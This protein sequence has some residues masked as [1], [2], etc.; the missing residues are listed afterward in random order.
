[1]RIATLVISLCLLG[2]GNINAQT[3]E[4]KNPSPG[5]IVMSDDA[6]PK[7]TFRAGASTIDV[8]AERGVSVQDLMVAAKIRPT[9]DPQTIVDKVSTVR[10]RLYPDRE[11]SLMVSVPRNS[12][13]VTS[14]VGL[15]RY[16][17]LWNRTSR[18]NAYWYPMLAAATFISDV[19][20]TW[21]YYECN[22][23]SKYRY[24]AQI[25]NG[26]SYTRALAGGYVYRGFDYQPATYG[27]R[28]DIVMYFF[29]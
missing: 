25:G 24:A 10:A 1:V 12:E 11:I 9:D 18:A 29:N 19:R 16:Y 3:F 22:G 28:A 21:R 2:V 5:A 14:G 7:M 6:L 26:G 15:W 13:L 27:A 17:L 20:G 4:F 8:R 23:C